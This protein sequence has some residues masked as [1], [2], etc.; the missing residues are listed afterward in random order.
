VWPTL[1]NGATVVPVFLVQSTKP[2]TGLR[3]RSTSG[4]SSKLRVTWVDERNI[5]DL[6]QFNGQFKFFIRS[7]VT[8]PTR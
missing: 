4:R 1:P 5:V 6:S 7:F 8:T 2:T 3:N